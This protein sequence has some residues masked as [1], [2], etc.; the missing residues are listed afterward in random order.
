MA[1]KKKINVR[2][3]RDERYLFVFVMLCVNAQFC[4]APSKEAKGAFTV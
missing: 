2:V 4:L 3:W 1:D